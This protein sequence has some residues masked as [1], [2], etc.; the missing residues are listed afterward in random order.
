MFRDMRQ[1]DMVRPYFRV[2]SPVMAGANVGYARQV[3]LESPKHTC[4]MEHDTD[5]S[6]MPT[7]MTPLRSPH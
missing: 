7:P 1:F 3:E 6:G 5:R 2:D 4:G